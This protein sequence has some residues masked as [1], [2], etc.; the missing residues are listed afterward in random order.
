[1]PPIRDFDGNELEAHEIIKVP[2]EFV[3]NE[4]ILNSDVADEYRAVKQTRHLAAMY[5]LWAKLNELIE[6]ADVL[7]DKVSQEISDIKVCFLS[8]EIKVPSTLIPT[9]S[10]PV[11]GNPFDDD[12]WTHVGF[13]L[14]C[15]D[16]DSI[17][18]KICFDCGDLNACGIKEIPFCEQI[19]ACPLIPTDPVGCTTHA[20]LNDAGQIVVDSIT[21]PLQQWRDAVEEAI[22][23]YV[24]T[25]E[26]IAAEI[27][28]GDEGD[29]MGAYSRWLTC[30][31]PAFSGAIPPEIS[32]A[33]ATSLN[34][35]HEITDGV[36]SF[37]KWVANNTGKFAWAL[38]PA[39]KLKQEIKPRLYEGLLDGLDNMTKDGSVLDSLILMRRTEHDDGTLNEEFKY[40][41]SYN[42][43]LLLIPDVAQ[44]VRNEMMI[45]PNTDQ[46]SPNDYP[47]IHNSVVLSKLLLLPVQEINRMVSE[48]GVVSTAYGP[49]LYPNN[50]PLSALLAWHDPLMAAINGRNTPLHMLGSAVGAWKGVS[51]KMRDFL[52]IGTTVI[53]SL[54]QK[55][56]FVSGRTVRSGR[57]CLK[58]YS[59]V[60]SLLVLLICCL[61][62]IRSVILF[63]CPQPLKRSIMFPPSLT[64]RPFRQ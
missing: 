32:G 58:K 64:H 54:I 33:C 62:D 14:G 4:L 56:D 24:L 6:V 9:W 63:R 37:N 18:E 36:E 40:N 15:V 38:V 55:E 22:R 27:M 21:L 30:W 61:R 57:R 60:R 29:P 34:V 47:V 19:N 28:R 41:S 49:N 5:D 35:F 12:C 26:E 45:D 39:T 50:S 2:E 3:M 17:Y 20:I 25:Q 46:W 59:K 52:K 8:K 42:K 11:P 31:G 7:G 23:Q 13:D 10:C 16:L 53:V 44:R 48:A 51:K 1:M 43:E